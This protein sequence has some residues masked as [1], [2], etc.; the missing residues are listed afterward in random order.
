MISQLLV[1]GY[2]A[3]LPSQHHLLIL[4]RLNPL[5]LRASASI[6]AMVQPG[7]FCLPMTYYEGVMKKI[8]AMA[9]EDMLDE[10]REACGE[11]TA[12]QIRR[13]S[14]I[15]LVEITAVDH[16]GVEHQLDPICKKK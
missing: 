4:S 5:N 6:C 15:T 13:S 12:D 9:K 16:R 2:K 11:A 3:R 7:V 1:I 14:E 8:N 10:L